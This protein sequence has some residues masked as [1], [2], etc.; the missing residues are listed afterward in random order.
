MSPVRPA[1]RLE[2]F[3]EY[4]F[5]RLA[6]AVAKTEA[7]TGRKVLGFGA[8]SPDYPPSTKYL[9][10]FAEFIHE[11]GIHMYPGY[12]GTK[13]FNNALIGWY[14]KRFGILLE[15][16][17]VFPLLGG[18]DGL[19]H[20][21]FALLDE[22]DEVLLPDPGY[23]GFDGPTLVAGGVPVPYDASSEKN[24]IV[25]A[26]LEKKLTARTRYIWINF[27]SNPTGHVA[28][29]ALLEKIVEFAKARNLPVIYDNAYSEI[30]YDGFRAPSILQVNGAKEI[31]VEVGSFSKT[32]SFAGLRMGWIVGNKDIVNALAKVKSQMDSGMF[33]PLQRLG[34]FVLNNQDIE[35]NEKML[36]SYKTRRDII[37]GKLEK[38]GLKFTLPK[39]ALYLWAKIPDSALNS[40]DYCMKLL[41]EKQVLFTPGTAYGKNGERFVRISFCVN[42]DRIDEYL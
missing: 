22:G 29:L 16:K 35:W 20:L 41:R 17:E 28:D 40:E 24:P 18:K 26:E 11:P 32:F 31:A 3:P 19:A 23:P 1:K 9:D 38:L 5:S 30:T 14:Q 37:A 25:L 42:V 13:E 4:I 21:P 10:R 34:A 39:G 33:L 6:K 12:S 2:K 15:E 36:D 8:G 27:P 7:A